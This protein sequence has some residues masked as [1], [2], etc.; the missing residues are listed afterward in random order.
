MTGVPATA[1]PEGLVAAVSQHRADADRPGRVDGATWLRT[2]PRLVDEALERWTLSVD[3]SVPLRYGFTALVVPVTRRRGDPGVLKVGWPHEESDTEHL[4]LRAWKGRGAVQLLA[5]DPASGTLLLERLD[6]DRDL[7]TGGVADTSEALGELLSRLDRPAPPWA[8]R[9]SRQLARVRDHLRT[10]SADASVA[11]RFPRRMLQQAASLAADL[12]AEDGARMRAAL[13]PQDSC[14]LVEVPDGLFEGFP[15]TGRY[16]LQI[17]Y[18]LAA[19]LLLPEALGRILYLDVEPRLL[20][21]RAGDLKLRGVMI[22]P[23]MTYAQLIAERDPLYRQWA[24]AVIECGEDDPEAVAARI[25][26][27]S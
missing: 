17:Y 2:L 7:T 6:A 12:T 16:P 21:L 24:D 27:E 18:R 26:L 5:A 9:L 23:G 19:P 25:G 8:P 20:E 13:R 14:T 22:Q 3:G 15:E 4:A 1:L 11:H 10:A